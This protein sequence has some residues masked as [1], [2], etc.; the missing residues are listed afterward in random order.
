MESLPSAGSL[1][2]KQH[3]QRGKQEFADKRLG[4]DQQR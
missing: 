3:E 2:D 1:R 4:H